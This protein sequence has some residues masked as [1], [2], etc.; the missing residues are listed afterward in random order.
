M[1]I[2]GRL[3]I[4]RY[5]SILGESVGRPAGSVSHVM[6]HDYPISGVRPKVATGS[7]PD[8][9]DSKF[10]YACIHACIDKIL[11]SPYMPYTRMT[12]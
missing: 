4:R 6:Y 3:T 10:M 1:W 12:M 5:G 8:R 7:C 9:N 2:N 11:A